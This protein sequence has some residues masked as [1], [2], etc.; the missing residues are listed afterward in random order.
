MVRLE[1]GETIDGRA[2]V[3][4]VEGPEAARLTGGLIRAPESK[5]T[6]CFYYA[7]PQPPITES[8][9][10]L[11]GDRTGPINNLCVP[12]NVAPT[13]APP[14]QALVSVSVVGRTCKRIRAIWKVPSVASCATGTVRRL[15]GG[16][17]CGVTTSG[18]PCPVSPRTFGTALLRS[19]DW[20]RAYIVAAITAR[21]LPSKGRW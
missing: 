13:Y 17:H 14:G 1:E 10:V 3:L 2:V 18:T 15:I 20:P 8:L 12:S 6:T 4:A 11:N 5:S 21:R 7:A 16:H 9:L 19:R